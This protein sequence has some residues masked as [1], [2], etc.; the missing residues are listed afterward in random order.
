MGYYSTTTS[1]V[2]SI[3]GANFAE[4]DSMARR[5]ALGD[6]T[7]D[8]LKAMSLQQAAA[9]IRSSSMPELMREAIYAQV[10]GLKAEVER[11][12]AAEV[13]RQYEERQEQNRQQ[14][15]SSPLPVWPFVLGGGVLL[16]LLLK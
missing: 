16:W 13:L 7:V 11:Q 5:L 10:P 14:E 15:Q 4:L 8:L 3:E 1:P 2:R 9:W 12:T 6:G